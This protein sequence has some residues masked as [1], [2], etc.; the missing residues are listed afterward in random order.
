MTSCPAGQITP[1]RGLIHLS[2]LRF[3]AA[4]PDDNGGRFS[5]LVYDIRA[6]IHR[7]AGGSRHE[8]SMRYSLL[9]IHYVQ[10]LRLRVHYEESCRFDRP[11]DN[12]RDIPVISRV[13]DALLSLVLSPTGDR[14]FGIALM[15]LA[16][17]VMGF[18]GLA[19]FTRYYSRR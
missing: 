16:Q 11:A 18:V 15:L 19:D 13:P 6:C 1:T 2:Q 3:A 10:P 14:Q 17:L 7:T 8:K 9:T 5:G 12:L 4:S